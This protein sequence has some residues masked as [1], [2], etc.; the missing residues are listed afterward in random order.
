M[1]GR[2]AIAVDNGRQQAIAVAISHE[3]QRQAESGASRID[4]EAMAA[5]VETAI[6]DG[7]PF[8]LGLDEGKQPDELNSSNDG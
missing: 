6:E 4:V 1:M 5:A 2:S 3:L 8:P 7:E